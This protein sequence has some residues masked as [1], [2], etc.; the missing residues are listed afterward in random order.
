MHLVSGTRVSH[1][2]VVSH[3][4]FWLV[5]GKGCI[6]LRPARVRI[7]QILG[8]NQADLAEERMR[9][10]RTGTSPGW[11]ENIPQAEMTQDALDG[12]RFRDARTC[13]RHV[14]R[15]RTDLT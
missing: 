12:R 11:V 4:A 1:T 3:G 13:L 5:F 15:H 8:G 14:S 10:R 7:R 2:P 6:G 9:I